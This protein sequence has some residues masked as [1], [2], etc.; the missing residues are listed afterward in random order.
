M[1]LRLLCALVIS[2]SM[3]AASKKTGSG[4]EIRIQNDSSYDVLVNIQGDGCQTKYR[5]QKMQPN[6]YM[7]YTV[8]VTPGFEKYT[9]QAIPL[10]DGKE[11]RSG[12]SKAVPMPKHDVHG[13]ATVIIKNHSSKLL[14]SLIDLE[15]QS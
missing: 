1:K 11:Q 12:N 6:E 10:K 14:G 13:K 2:A 8:A 5:D 3:S 9:V 15:L 4:F 7:S